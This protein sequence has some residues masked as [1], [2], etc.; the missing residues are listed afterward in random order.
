[1]LQNIHFPAFLQVLDITR[2]GARF[3]SSPVTRQANSRGPAHGDCNLGLLED[4]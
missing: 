1:M 4:S 3:M 2:F